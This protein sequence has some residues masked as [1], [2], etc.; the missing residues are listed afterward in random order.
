MTIGT[1]SVLY[2]AHCFFLHPFFVA[3]GWTKLYG[4]PWD[5]RLWIAFFVHDLGY[6]GKP[7]MDGEE[8]ER[9][10][11]VGGMICQ[12]LFGREWFDFC[13]LHSRFIAQTWDREPSRLCYADKL[14]IILTPKWLYM[15]MVHWTGE[16]EEYMDHAIAA[17]RNQGK[18]AGEWN[19]YDATG[20]TVDEWHHSMLTYMKGWL[21]DYEPTGAGRRLYG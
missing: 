4:F 5:P 10:V 16:V 11:F 20:L 13:V 12:R 7:N 9:H 2:G 1:R 3:W 14:A 19:Q 18:Y 15:P 17:R 6:I 8:G 21:R